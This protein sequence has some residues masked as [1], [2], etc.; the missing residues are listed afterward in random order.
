MRVPTSEMAG[1]SCDLLISDYAMLHLSGTELV[2]MA[3]ELHPQLS[4]LIITGYAEADAVNGR[5]D[6]VEILLKPFTPAVLQSAVL[7]T[8]RPRP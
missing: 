8:H 1:A 3:R 4:A 2:R 5:P 6:D 7:R